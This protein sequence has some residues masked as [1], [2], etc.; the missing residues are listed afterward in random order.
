MLKI[1]A[2]LKTVDRVKD[3]P[4]CTN[5]ELRWWKSRIDSNMNKKRDKNRLRHK[6]IKILRDLSMW[7]QLSSV[8]SLISSAAAYYRGI[9]LALVHPIKQ[10]E[11][12]FTMLI[13][14]LIKMHLKRP[15]TFETTY[16]TDSELEST[17]NSIKFNTSQH[18]IQY[19]GY[20]IKQYK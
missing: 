14:N 16:D 4:K 10:F 2:Q 6:K 5:H 9:C 19:I 13:L 17:K 3:L 7:K 15:S 8:V 18:H 12:Q 1:V 20:E 11:S